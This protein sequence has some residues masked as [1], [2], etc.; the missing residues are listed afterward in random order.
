MKKVKRGLVI[1]LFIISL[2]VFITAC[3]GSK[4]ITCNKPYIKVG[5][6]CCLDQNDN[7]ICD[8]DETVACN[9]PYIQVDGECCLDKDNDEYCDTQGLGP[10]EVT[11]PTELLEKEY[12]FFD[13]V[14][15]VWY[16]NMIVD[17]DLHR[18]DDRCIKCQL[19]SEAGQNINYKYCD[20][21]EYGPVADSEGN[22]L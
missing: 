11:C 6:A 7:G 17:N 10:G 12:K 15:G 13:A 21:F 9:E 16:Q 14:G 22:V 3:D 8:S 4:N 2:L 19:G 5:T 18:Q 1:C 20:E